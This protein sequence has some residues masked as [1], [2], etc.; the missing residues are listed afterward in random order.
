MTKN[1]ERNNDIFRLNAQFRQ[2]TRVMKN[3]KGHN[4]K[5][6][7]YVEGSAGWIAEQLKHKWPGLTGRAVLGV[8]QR[9]NKNGS[10]VHRPHGR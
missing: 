4:L 3:D 10:K 9:R 2:P 8:L 1:L 6:G 7:T 5:K